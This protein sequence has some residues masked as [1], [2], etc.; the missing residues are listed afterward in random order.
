MILSKT[1]VLV[2]ISLL[3]LG[4]SNQ[5]G[6]N[7]EPL[8]HEHT[9]SNYWAYSNDGH[10]HPATCGYDVISD[11][12][13]HT[14]GEWVFDYEPTE[15][16]SGL[17]H[18]TCIYCRYQEEES[19]DPVPHVHVP[20]VDEGCNKHEPTCVSDGYY[21][22]ITYCRTCGQELDV[23]RVIIPAL[24]HDLIHHDGL[25]PTCTKDGYTEYD[26]CT[27]CDYNSKVIIPKTGHQHL[28]TVEENRDEPTCEY[29]GSYDIVTRCSD[30]NV[31]I[32]S[33]HVTIPAL[34]HLYETEVVE[35][36]YTS[37][38]YTIYTCSRCGDQYKDDYVDRL[39]YII[40]FNPNGGVG[41]PTL[42]EKGHDSYTKLPDDKPTREGYV[43]V[44][45]NSYKSTTIY[46]PGNSIDFNYDDTLYALWGEECPKCHMSGCSNCSNRGYLLPDAPIVVER[47]DTFVRLEKV[48]GYEY[49][50][51]ESCSF[52]D[53]PLFTDLSPTKIYY[54][55]QR[56][57]NDDVSPY[58]LTSYATRIST[59]PLKEYEIR[60]D[61]DGGINSPDNP[62]TYNEEEEVILSNPHKPGYDFVC[63]SSTS[64][65]QIVPTTGIP[66]GST[67]N[68]VFKAVWNDGNFFIANLNPNGGII[69]ES[70]L[71]FQFNKTFSLPS[72][73]RDGYE[74]A[75]WSDGNKIISEN[76]KWTYTEDTTFI[77]QWTP[78]S[79]SI[80]YVLNGG[81]L[82]SYPA[83]YPN[84]YTIEDEFT[85][86]DP[87]RDGYIF[88]GWTKNEE[89]FS[90]IHKGMIGDITLEATWS[91]FK[92]MIDIYSTDIN[93]GEV[94]LVSG[95]GKTDEQITIEAIPYEGYV[96]AYWKIGNDITVTDATYTFKMPAHNILAYAYFY[97]IEEVSGADPLFLDENTLTYGIYPQERVTDEALISSLEELNEPSFYEWYLYEDH[98]YAKVDTLLTS[99]ET[100]IFNDGEEIESGK[101][102]W[103]K[104]TPITWR[105]LETNEDEYYLLSDLA[106][107][108]RAIGLGKNTNNY[109]YYWLSNRFNSLA[110]SHSNY[111]SISVSLPT[112]NDCS[113]IDYGFNS[114]EDRICYTS[115][116]A[117]A[118][119]A[120]IITYNNGGTNYWITGSDEFLM[121]MYDGKI[122]IDG[123]ATSDTLHSVRPAIKVTFDKE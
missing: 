43:F 49:C 104:C 47:G 20:F 23:T 85:I 70:S 5:N 82:N 61:L 34:G 122:V 12:A 94:R 84:K 107:D 41:G 29:P 52:Q 72:P 119:G 79:Y 67:G 89:P 19:V 44:G 110:F 105:I 26:T 51:N 4:C 16:S 90:G 68:K 11:Y 76:E 10:W 114:D 38:G 97:S 64:I 2:A 1:F 120:E 37:Q 65:G 8:P 77:A 66:Y 28:Y 96:F 59:T 69:S 111:K 54:F 31:I 57:A 92:Y 101:T 98:Y 88:N 36:T 18:R 25:A 62:E 6:N 60:Y 32:N 86:S 55:Y 27:R 123:E 17:K 13:S 21:E 113:N 71:S 100:H 81:K 56:K 106:I 112:K 9:F 15:Y 48:E 117:R 39:H 24:G 30:D 109:L 46:S 80:T 116:Y 14:F 83:S 108:A 35:P 103:F 74:F 75:G 33:E 7:S 121:V 93:R 40:N 91:P 118:K 73:T 22:N 78:I 99:Y 45:W 3:L 50:H 102:Y 42:I 58:G 95:E 53:S 63:W 115:D 87:I